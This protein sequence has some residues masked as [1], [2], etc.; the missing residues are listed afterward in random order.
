MPGLEKPGGAWRSLALPMAVA[1][2]GLVGCGD[3]AEGADGLTEAVGAS[4]PGACLGGFDSGLEEPVG[5]FEDLE[6]GRY[7]E[8]LVVFIF[9]KGLLH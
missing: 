8:V 1:L 7:C 9:S 3:G 6:S 4:E 5:T 2:S